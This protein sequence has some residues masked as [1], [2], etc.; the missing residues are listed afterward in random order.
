MTVEVRRAAG[1]T[2]RRAE[3]DGFA[4]TMTRLR[5]AYD[6]MNQVWP[7]SDPPEALVEAMQTGDRIGYHPETAQEEIAHLHALLPTAKASVDKIGDTIV[8]RLDEFIKRMA[9]ESWRPAGIDMEAQKQH[10]IDAMARARKLL[11]EAAN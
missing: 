1:L 2:A 7:V 4:G 3:L 5:A 11:T 6:A 9:A 8:P 10:R